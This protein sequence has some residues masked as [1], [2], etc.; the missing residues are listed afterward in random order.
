MSTHAFTDMYT[1]SE[2]RKPKGQRE[3]GEMH[4][5]THT[6]IDKHVE[7]GNQSTPVAVYD[8]ASW[9]CEY[10]YPLQPVCCC[11]PNLH[12]FCSC[13]TIIFQMP[14]YTTTILVWHDRHKTKSLFNFSVKSVPFSL[15]SRCHNMYTTTI[16]VWH[17]IHKTK[18]L[19]DF[20]VNSVLTPWLLSC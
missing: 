14:Q 10:G 3:R 13:T 19:F 4:M 1:H 16:L 20:S 18:H 12:S 6:F 15:S 17:N 8:W 5:Y 7:G 9:W 11:W 2:G